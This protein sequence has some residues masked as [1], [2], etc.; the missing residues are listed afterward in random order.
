M[1]TG[2]GYYDDLPE[3]DWLEGGAKKAVDEFVNLKK[4]E[5]ITVARFAKKKKGFDLIPIVAQKLS[6]FNIDY[7]WT[8]I[9]KNTDIATTTGI[10]FGRGF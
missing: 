7:R 6:E 1:I 10:I 9:G 8:I 2:D 3:N 5:L 4:L